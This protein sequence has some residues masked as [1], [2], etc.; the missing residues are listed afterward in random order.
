MIGDVAHSED[1]DS[2][3]GVSECL[4]KGD[5][6]DFVQRVDSFE[7]G[8]QLEKTKLIEKDSV[9]TRRKGRPPKANTQKEKELLP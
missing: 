5:V 9:K 3:E 1:E 6:K 8:K 2:E 4:R 7:Y